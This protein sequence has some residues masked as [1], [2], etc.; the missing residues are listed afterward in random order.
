M[1][2]ILELNFCFKCWITSLSNMYSGTYCI[3]TALCQKLV[4]SE[5][6]DLFRCLEK[7][8]TIFNRKLWILTPKGISSHREIQ[9]IILLLSTISQKIV[10]KWLLIS[11]SWYYLNSNSIHFDY[12]K[13]GIYISGNT[14]LSLEIL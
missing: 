12:Y 13:N 1:Y 6:Q 5:F 9:K 14:I 2:K 10:L 7:S 8:Y 3:F 4:L 11:E